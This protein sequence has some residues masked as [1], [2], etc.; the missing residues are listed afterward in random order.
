MFGL[1]I[2]SISEMTLEER[3]AKDLYNEKMQQIQEYLRNKNLPPALS[4]KVFQY[5][6]Y[7]YKGRIFEERL[8]LDN[9]NP[10]LK[11]VRNSGHYIILNFKYCIPSHQVHGHLKQKTCTKIRPLFGEK[12]RRWKG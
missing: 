3:G 6:E 12:C 9:L 2:G 11:R 8:M 5:F 4:K 10:E 7:K 1:C